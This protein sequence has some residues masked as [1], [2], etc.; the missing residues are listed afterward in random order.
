LICSCLPLA[1]GEALVEG[2]AAEINPSDVLTLI[3]Q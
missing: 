3:G 2:L 1:A